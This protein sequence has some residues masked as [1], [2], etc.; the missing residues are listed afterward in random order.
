M[1]IWRKPKDEKKDHM[2]FLQHLAGHDSDL[3]ITEFGQSSMLLGKYDSAVEADTYGFTIRKPKGRVP[4]DANLLTAGQVK[5]SAHKMSRNV[6]EKLRKS[7]TDRGKR[8]SDFTGRASLSVYDSVYGILENR[9]CAFKASEHFHRP[10]ILRD[11]L[12]EMADRMKGGGVWG[13]TTSI[14]GEKDKDFDVDWSE[15]RQYLYGHKTLKDIK[16]PVIESLCRRNKDLLKRVKDTKSATATILAALEIASNFWVGQEKDASGECG[17]SED[18]HT[19]ACG[20]DTIDVN[21]V[22]AGDLSEEEENAV[23][24][25]IIEEVTQN[26]TED[27]A[28]Q[29]GNQAGVRT[30]AGIKELEENAT[31]EDVVE[32]YVDN[33]D[34]VDKAYELT[35]GNKCG[36]EVYGDFPTVQYTTT[37]DLSSADLDSQKDNTK[38]IRGTRGSRMHR[39]GW[40]LPFF[41]DPNVFK[42]PP[43]TSADLVVLIDISASMGSPTSSF[44][45]YR[46]ALEFATAVR[47]RFPEAV[48]YGFTRS[49]IPRE[50]NAGLFPITATEVPDVGRGST[51]MCGAL[52]GLEE[53]HNLDNARILIITD[54]MPNDCN[55]GS[56]NKCVVNRVRA[57][58]RKGIRFG[59]IHIAEF[60]RR[61][62]PLPTEF[63]VQKKVWQSATPADIENVFRFLK[64]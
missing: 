56:P 28:K 43:I 49:Q 9:R 5:F 51:P 48:V 42:K 30:T 52:K 44:S 1:K 57:W 24:E 16:N 22:S 63:T 53:L 20:T 27:Y 47:A 31:F 6:R 11:H 32:D 19:I 13:Y 21:D 61:D 45:P 25:S 29:Q 54:G 38:A 64:G 41:G 36:A 23:T 4:F 2:N 39:N 8:K 17:V 35:V 58:T 26:T 62:Y 15:F 40:R 59:V 12:K 34:A 10:K 7:L 55:S 37:L 50:V 46:T 33:S 14:R 60:T 3:S 18:S